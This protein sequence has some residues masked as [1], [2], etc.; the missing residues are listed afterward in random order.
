MMCNGKNQSAS[1]NIN[2]NEERADKRK[3]NI[4]LR[5]T[6]FILISKQKYAISK[7]FIGRVN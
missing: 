4:V 1:I 2:K 3:L 5:Y 7:S 6:V